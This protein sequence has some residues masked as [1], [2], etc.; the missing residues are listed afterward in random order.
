MLVA[1]A[2][3]PR[4][5]SSSCWVF[6][7][8]PGLAWCF[9]LP[10]AGPS[11]PPRPQ[12]PSSARPSASSNVCSCWGSRRLEEQAQNGLAGAESAGHTQMGWL[13]EFTVR[14]HEEKAHFVKT[15]SI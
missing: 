11:S 15:W 7:A 5:W 14:P 12:M 4:P 1:V 8:W 9:P 10:R 13:V 3:N 2:P 6:P